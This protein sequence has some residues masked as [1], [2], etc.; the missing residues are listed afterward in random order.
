MRGDGDLFAFE[1]GGQRPDAG[2]GARAAEAED[3]PKSPPPQEPGA[4]APRIWVPGEV[5][6][7]GPD[8]P[9]MVVIPAGEFTMGSPPGEEGRFDDEG[10]QHGVRIGKAFALGKY[11]TVGNFK[12]FLE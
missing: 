8:A 2:P 1:A 12:R 5:F 6:R 9:E 3:Q 4:A 7:D 10:P 11:A